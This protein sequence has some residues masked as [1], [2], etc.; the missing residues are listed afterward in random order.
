M[1]MTGKLALALLSGAFLSFIPRT[2]PAAAQECNAEFESTFA[3]I[4]KAIFENHGCTSGGCHS[5][6]FP[7]GGLDLSPDV[8]WENLVDQPSVTP[9]GFVRVVPG[10]KDESL[11][12]LNLAAATL[13]GQWQ[14]P[15]RAMPQG[16]LPPLSLDELEA[17]RLWIERG[18]PK[19]GTVPGTGELLDACLPPEKPIEVKPLP[20]PAPGEGV[21]IHMPRWILRAHTEREVC[22]ASY[23]DVSDQV[24]AEFRGPNGD[25]FRYKRNQI[26][27]DSLS[28]HLIVN[29]YRGEYDIDSPI[30]GTF[31][32][33]GGERDGQV[34]NPKEIGFCGPGAG[35]A[36]DPSN[37]VACIGARNI[38]PDAGVGI[39]SAGLVGTQETA[40]QQDLPA[41]VYNEVPLRGIIIWNSHAFNLTSEDGKL[42]AWLNFD[43]APPED[44]VHPLR[45]IFNTS[46]I[47]KMNVP[48]F[49]TEEVCHHHVLPPRS[50]LFELSSH[51]HQRGKRWRTFLG[52]FACDG[53]PNAG[54]PCQPMGYDLSSPDV[55]AGA[56]C[57]SK[58][59]PAGG[60]CNGDL[61]VSV[62]ELVLSVN[63]ALGLAPR[64]DCPRADIDKNGAVDI[65]EIM[66][67]IVAANAPAYR[68]PVQ[69]LL[70]TSFLYNDPVTVNFDP[71]I[72]FPGADS[73]PAERTLT[74]CSLYD[75]GF[76]NPAEVKKRSVTPTN[77]FPC[78]ATHCTTGKSGAACRGSSKAERDTS[79]DS[80]PG[81]G[82]GLC[83]ACT[84]NGGVTTEDEMFLLLGSYFV[85]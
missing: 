39:S 36:N 35:C 41:G 16:G 7:A 83:D 58:M 12:W 79:C 24:P 38:P 56:P 21:Q 69:S 78:F 13:P 77:S 67:G 48:A 30:W 34:C 81:A 28:H 27:Q 85:R 55:C 80:S 22:Y 52:R 11:L 50:E 31:K 33:R 2:T 66:T 76:T 9:P 15:L 32:C 3:L 6:S 84:L 82:D 68:D 72:S 60:D 45:G 20:P 1:K 65:S 46:E 63:I 64:R 62:S 54:E 8:A 49:A 70:Y 23:Y 14:A 43:F 4:Q 26:R 44:Q 29:L 19:E 25:T 10:Q 71:P 5:G 51:T 61:Q 18:A 73:I 57:R 47:F 74:Y 53:G 40:R 59:P 37:A 17:V 42:E 75:N